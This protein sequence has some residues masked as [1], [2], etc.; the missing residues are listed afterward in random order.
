MKR[1]TLFIILGAIGVIA[2]IAVAV[3]ARYVSSLSELRPLTITFP[4]SMLAV[5]EG[6]QCAG[7]ED[8]TGGI[9]KEILNAESGFI[10]IAGGANPIPDDVWA[11]TRFRLPIIKNSTRN[12]L[13]N[14]SCFFRSPTAPADCQGSA[15]F[16]IVGI[17]GYTWLS[18]TRIVGQEC[19]PDAAGCNGDVVNPG[20]VSIS[21]IGKCHRIVYNGP[22]IY[23]LTNAR[24]EQFVMHA[25]ADGVPN[26]TPTLPAGWTLEARTIDSP[27]EVLPV[28][29]AD[30]CYHNVLRDHLV[31]SYHQFRWVSDVYPPP[32]S[33]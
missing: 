16:E 29:T 25:T 19:F 15:C 12:L 9:A 33:S 32:A 6:A 4:T 2:L 21:T 7:S 10:Y 17:D 23:V 11:T 18:L 24:G 1:S 27:L 20:Y 8:V 13:F 26:L 5:P 22:T 14:G 31:Q 30:A 3:I 28:G